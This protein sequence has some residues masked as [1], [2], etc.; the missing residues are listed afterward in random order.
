[1]QI[2]GLIIYIA[3]F[4]IHAP[5]L[6]LYSL[7]ATSQVEKGVVTPQTSRSHFTVFRNTALLFRHQ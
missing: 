5:F 7:N 4:N 2:V 1:M 3:I 6:S